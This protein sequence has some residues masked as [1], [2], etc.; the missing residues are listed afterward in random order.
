MPLRSRATLSTASAPAAS[1]MS[2][3][4]SVPSE[5]AAWLPP[6]IG[7]VL[8]NAHRA[9]LELRPKE[10]QQDDVGESTSH[11]NGDD[12]AVLVA[13]DGLAVLFDRRKWKSLANPSFDGRA[14]GRDQVAQLVRSADNEGSEASWAQLHEMYGNHTPSTGRRKKSANGRH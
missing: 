11:E 10:S 13:L 14:G 7:N 4:C 6:T 12:S 1:C 8:T 2:S 3:S 5:L 9:T